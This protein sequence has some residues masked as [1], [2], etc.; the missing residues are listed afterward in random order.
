MFRLTKLQIVLVAGVFALAACAPTAIQSVSGTRPTVLVETTEATLTEATAVP[1]AAAVELPRL[2]VSDVQI[3]IGVGSPIPVDALISGELPDTC[4]QLAEFKQTVKDF[5]FE[6]ALAV[7]PGTREECMRDTL[8]FRI[9]VP[10]NMVN[11][12]EGTYSV[13]ANG[14]STTFRWPSEPT[15]APE[16]VMTIP[17]DAP[18]YRNDAIGFELKHPQGWI[19]EE[20]GD[21]DILW[22]E[23]PGGPGRDG[24]PPNIVK[25]DITTEPNT[26]MTL[27]ELVARQKQIIA[28][29]NGQILLEESVT[30]PSGLKAVRLGV[31]GFGE[32]VTL[33]TV[34]NGHPVMLTGYGDLV[35][36]D[37]IA[38][39]L[40]AVQP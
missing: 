16:P 32:S 7:A 14:A 17:N 34:I 9:A 12:P 21:T 23:K 33:W 11:L 37:A 19:I 24:V 29:S 31:S 28:D 1:T 8:P 5:A 20:A 36:F 4:A 40:R 27:E 30:L 25:I 26:T 18:T 39:T 6:I 15:T 38:N 13:K 22:S 35:R 10:L 3:Q 2:K